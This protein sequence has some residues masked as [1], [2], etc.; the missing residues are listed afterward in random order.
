LRRSLK[1]VVVA[2]VLFLSAVMFILH[3]SGRLTVDQGVDLHFLGWAWLHDIDEDDHV[4]LMKRD[5]T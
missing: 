4:G 2:F 5:G 3:V 1:F